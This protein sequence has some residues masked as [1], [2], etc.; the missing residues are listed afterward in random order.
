MTVRPVKHALLVNSD[1]NLPLSCHNGTRELRRCRHC[2]SQPYALTDSS[3]S[4]PLGTSIFLN[5]VIIIS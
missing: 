3:A 5:L 2:I 1:Y 4:L